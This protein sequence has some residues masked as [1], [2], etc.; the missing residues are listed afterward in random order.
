MESFDDLGSGDPVKAE[1]AA[2]ALV[3]LG[4]SVLPRLAPLSLPTFG[5]QFEWRLRLIFE[6]LGDAATEH[7]AEVIEHGTWHAKSIAAYAFPRRAGQAAKKLHTLAHHGNFDVQ[8]HGIVAVGRAGC[9]IECEGIEEEVF[10]SEYANQK[11]GHYALQAFAV[12]AET[13]SGDFHERVSA[14]VRVPKMLERGMYADAARR[15]D[16]AIERDFSF[17]TPRVADAVVH[18]WLEHTSERARLLGVKALQALRLERTR[19]RLAV[20]AVD[21][22]QPQAIRLAA[23]TCLAD[24]GGEDCLEA[25][26]AA[27]RDLGA[28]LAE[29]LARAIG[30]TPHRADTDALLRTLHRS[31]DPIALPHVL[32][33]FGFSGTPDVDALECATR[34][35]HDSERW[36]AAFA[37]GR[38]GGARATRLL[39]ALQR[40]AGTNWERAAASTGL[41]HAGRNEALDVLRGAMSAPDMTGI[42]GMLHYEQRREILSAFISALGADHAHVACWARHLRVD[43]ARAVDELAQLVVPSEQPAKRAQTASV[44]TSAPIASTD[45]RKAVAWLHFT[46]FHQGLSGQKHLWARVKDELGRDL[47]RTVERTGPWEFVAFTGDLTQSASDAEFERL[48]ETL[49]ELWRLFMERCGC[50]P[51]LVAVPGNHDLRWRDPA[52]AEVL[53]LLDFEENPE[54]QDAFWNQP[55]SAYRQVLDEAFAPYLKWWKASLPPR[56]GTSGPA[57]GR[58]GDS[59]GRFSAGGS[60]RAE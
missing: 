49:G 14:L 59:C 12:M 11:L 47:E 52:D 56:A 54:V 35:A 24:L 26:A 20:L 42:V 10:S 29:H 3:A 55:S 1:A 4:P 41:V 5:P 33:A 9:T 23:C 57:P 34:S 48:N 8:R 43:L 58:S 18:A 2:S 53:L 32:F 36:A 19:S 28:P 16:A 46:D 40:E 50:N 31:G 37:L 45:G 25:V 27:H 39:E 38:V 30:N 15:Y 21:G 17:Y 51:Q 6:T 13:C 60:P 7:L 22:N 44:P